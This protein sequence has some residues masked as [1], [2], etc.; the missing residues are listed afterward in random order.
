MKKTLNEIIVKLTGS[1]RSLSVLR[2]RIPLLLLVVITQFGAF[3]SYSQ[4]DS[5]NKTIQG[6][7]TDE[8]SAP[9]PGVT[10]MERGT[11]NG[12]ISNSN[13]DYSIEVQ[14]DTARLVFS[15]VG[16]EKQTVN[17]EGKTSI[18]VEMVPSSVSLDEVVAVGYGT[19]SKKNLTTSI[20]KV[21][22]DDV[23]K[24]ANSNMSQ[25]LM[26]RAAGLQATMASAQPGG[27]VDISI[28]GAGNP[29]YVV[30]GVQMPTSSL[31]PGSGGSTTSV[32]SSID[33][34]GLAGLNPEDIESVEV[35]KDASSSIYGIGAANGVI[36]IT[37][38]SGK[39]GPMQVSYDASYS[40]VEN[41]DYIQPLD[42][43]NYMT[44]A[45]NFSKEQ[46]L[47]NNDMGAFGPNEYDDGWSP[48]Y[49]EPEI[50]EATTTGWL[51]ELLKTGHIEQHNLVING[52]SE[53]VDYYVSGNYFDQAGSVANSGMNRYALRSKVQ[54]RLFPFLRLTST[55]NVN[56]N[57][58]K[59]SSAGG[60]SSGRG[61]EASGSL[62]SAI[63]YPPYLPIRNEE[64]DY[65][66][67]QNIP[68]AIAMQEIDDDT[69]ATGSNL[70][71]VADIDLIKN[72]LTGKLL[73]GNN[74]EKNNRELYIPSYVYFDQMY[75]SRGNIA[76]DNRENE[77]YEATLN[78]NKS[79]DDL[80]V[81]DVVAGVGKY[82][83]S[84][85]GVNVAYDE[86]HDAIGNDDIS[87]AS[88]VYKPDSYRNE[89][90]KRSQ[91]V[92]THFDFLDRYV[93]AATLRRD[94]TDKFFPDKKYAYFPSI[95]VAWK[96]SNE[97]FFDAVSWIDLLKIR[98]S[99]GETGS[100]NLGTDL[101][102]MYGTFSRATFD[103]GSVQYIP[104]VRR[105]LDYP[106]V[107]WQKTTKQNLGVDFYVLNNR[108]SGS[109]DLFRD[110]I[111]DMLG[112]AN[113][114]GLSMFGEY[115]INGAHLRREGWDASVNG[116][117]VNT[118]QFL[119]S[120]T[121]TLS[122]YDAI[123]KERMPNYDFNDYELRE[124]APQ[125]ARY[126]YETSG[127]IN[128]DMS[129]MPESQPEEA[130]LPGYPIIVDQNNDGEITVDDIR[131]NNEVPDIYFGFGNRFAY[132]NFDLDIFM[133]SQ[134]GVNKYN[135]A[136]DWAH[137]GNLAN[138]V[139]NENQFAKRL[140]HSEENP[141]GTIPGIAWNLANVALPGNA[142]TDINYQDASFLRVRN[143]TLGYNIQD[144]Q[145]GQFRQ[146]LSNVRIYV[147]AQNPLTFTN[148]EGFDPEVRSGGGY[149]GGKAEYPQTRTFSAGLKVNFN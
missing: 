105:G 127:L 126:F 89:D 21:N 103:G 13:G 90:E 23:S 45:N 71:F 114:P 110:D 73:Y 141:D 33:R 46:Y 15:F 99:Y 56:R 38:K 62:T 144:N 125:N 57:Q 145:L 67:Y 76:Y 53:K 4:T 66:A 18:D 58:Y 60:T 19:V 75:K 111:T 36:L 69:Y 130:Q 26:G 83:N 122:K 72:M 139:N 12:T 34:S 16:M 124:D 9:M 133:Y 84:G 98:A 27:D 138:E 88:G 121:L 101:Y 95:S 10:V 14:T 135:Y 128:A 35:L 137:A 32:P 64:G 59:N 1:C 78:F 65:T 146:Y 123:Y 149:K 43:Q 131:M 48:R 77:T 37:T 134:L 25:L 80:L 40:T 142:G 8:S 11:S 116:K 17:T 96:M 143:I 148:F 136:M 28:R 113:S 118:N 85:K 49:T 29:N 87:S 6:K 147:E 54:L 68:N 24:S 41:Y 91:F 5:E 63:S 119:W 108:L 129:N 117:I 20:S 93:L 55:V 112:E 31:E 51:D 30:D 44:L 97:N 47:Y 109:F 70:N 120:S 81:L 94:G 79:F 106:D 104:I 42:A 74:M 39:E 132:K 107:S 52:G 3:N 86:Q 2:N 115:P 22:T 92:R 102:G 50:S 61:P 140:W 82:L 7:I 100:D